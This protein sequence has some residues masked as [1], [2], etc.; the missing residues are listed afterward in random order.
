MFKKEVWCE[1]VQENS[2]SVNRFRF[3]ISKRKIPSVDGCGQRNAVTDIYGRNA[4][5]ST[6]HVYKRADSE[7]W[8]GSF[9]KADIG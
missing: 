3:R 2:A 6:L 7:T 5:S 9:H 1:G 8:V 4:S